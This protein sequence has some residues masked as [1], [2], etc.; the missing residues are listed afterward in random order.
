MN[1]WVSLRENDYITN[2]YVIVTTPWE[3][4][5]QS[6]I[7]YRNGCNIIKNSSTL[8]S[9]SSSLAIY[10][11]NKLCKNYR[12]EFSKFWFLT[13][14]GA[15]LWHRISPHSQTFTITQS[16]EVQFQANFQPD[17]TLSYK[18]WVS[19]NLGKKDLITPQVN[20]SNN[21]FYFKDK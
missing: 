17:F 14:N 1:I 4:C 10:H 9:F 21:S 19:S 8:F 15:S 20:V 16:A 12:K 13:P 11:N 3:C 6:M 7:L 18:M 2:D 5:L